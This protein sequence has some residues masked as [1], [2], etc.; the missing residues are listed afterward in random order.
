M[1]GWDPA[2]RAGCSLLQKLAVCLTVS[3]YGM[4]KAALT[5]KGPRAS[6]HRVACGTFLVVQRAP[7]FDHVDRLLVGPSTS[8]C[9]AP[10][11]CRHCCYVEAFDRSKAVADLVGLATCAASVACHHALRLCSGSLRPSA[12]RGAAQSPC[13]QASLNATGGRPGHPD[14]TQRP[15]GRERKKRECRCSLS[16]TAAPHKLLLCMRNTLLPATLKR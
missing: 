2:P 13:R 16:T 4:L 15:R 14:A 9:A 7:S 10:C 6:I 1:L 11:W 5:L 8:A 3:V 12:Q